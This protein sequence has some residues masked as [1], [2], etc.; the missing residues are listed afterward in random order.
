MNY[1]AF[2]S[3]LQSTQ[4]KIWPIIESYLPNPKISRHAAMIYEYPRRKGK[5]LRPTLTLLANQLHNGAETD[6][7]LTAAAIQL[8]EEWLLIHDDIEDHSDE[9]RS[10]KYEYNPTLNAIYGDELAINT[11]DALHAIMWQILKDSILK[12]NPNASKIF[13]LMQHTIQK[14]IEGQFLELS[15]IRNH[16]VTI[17]HKEYFRM[18]FRKSALYSVITPLQIGALTAGTEDKQQLKKISEWGK[19]FGLAFQL[20]DDVMNITS[21]SEIQ[22][23]EK[24]GDIYEGKRTLLLLHLLSK[25]KQTEKDYIISIYLKKRSK[26]NAKEINYIT[27]AMLHYGSIAYTQDMARTYSNKALK[28]FNEYNATL[29]PNQAARA[30]RQGIEFVVNRTR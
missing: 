29:P 9:R 7:H 2:L 5:Y 11:G 27:A 12:N 18:I 16:Q 15:W 30:I 19:Y 13:N 1:E 28:L 25:C 23:K 6:A 17:N 8:S 21:T 26:K 20:W 22:G 24:A 3:A 14:T 10:T 4:E